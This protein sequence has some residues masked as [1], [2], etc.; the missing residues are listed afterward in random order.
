MLSIAKTELESAKKEHIALRTEINTL[1]YNQREN[2]SCCLTTSLD[3]IKRINEDLLKINQSDECE[4]TQLKQQIAQLYQ[5]KNKIQQC[6][7]QLNNKIENIESHVGYDN[8]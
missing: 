4:C 2:L 1:D 6:A 7:L 8:N 5:E 3:H